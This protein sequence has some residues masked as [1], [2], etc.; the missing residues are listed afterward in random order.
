MFVFCLIINIS[1]ISYLDYFQSDI[2][3]PGIKVL[4]E[5]EI[6]R[7]RDANVKYLVIEAAVLIEVI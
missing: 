4:L 6:Q 5:A 2:V 3:W 7:A 1:I